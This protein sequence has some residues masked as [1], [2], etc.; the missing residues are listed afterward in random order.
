M[1]ITRRHFFFL[2]V[3]SAINIAGGVALQFSGILVLGAGVATDAYFAAQAVPMLLG[4]IL[5]GALANNLTPMLAAL[6]VP[7]RAALVR[8]VMLQMTLP[9][10]ALLVLLSVTAPW[11]S[12]FL[13][14][15][16]PREGQTLFVAL[17]PV[18][19]ATLG[20]TVITSAGVAG[21]SAEGKFWQTEMAQCGAT[22]VALALAVPVT[23]NYGMTGFTWL[24]LLRALAFFFL[25]GAPYLRA[26]TSPV[27]EHSRVLWYRMAQ[28]MSGSIIFKLGPVLDRALASLAAPGVITSLGIGQQIANSVAGVTDK[29]L[30]R[31]LLA[32]AGEHLA[33]NKRKEVIQLYFAQLRMARRAAIAVVGFLLVLVVSYAASEG[34]ANSLNLHAFGRADVI[35]LVSLS[36]LPMAASQLSASLMYAIGNPRIISRLATISFLASSALKVIGFMLVGVYAIIAG[37]FLYQILNWVLLHRSAMRLLRH[38]K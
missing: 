8:V 17:F 28:I 24:L 14:F 29:A 36:A 23:K 18:M 7:T 27:A 1:P 21:R 4:A 13:F 22:L 16:L 25:V 31:P 5:A 26:E 6:A 30:S 2:S 33:A 19:C 3:L 9:L 35:I 38:P 12:S 11:W 20:V 15:G 10:A 34:L 37:V 32:A